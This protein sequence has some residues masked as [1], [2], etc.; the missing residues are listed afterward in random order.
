MQREVKGRYEEQHLLALKVGGT[1][2]CPFFIFDNQR[3]MVGNMHSR[4]KEKFRNVPRGA[5]TFLI[6]VGTVEDEE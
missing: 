5:L 6:S 4:L 3:A 1:H 2:F